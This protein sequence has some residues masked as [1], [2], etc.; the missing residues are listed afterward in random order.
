MLI[1]SKYWN[2]LKEF[3]QSETIYFQKKESI[4]YEHFR[5]IQFYNIYY[6]LTLFYKYIN[7]V[8]IEISFFELC[9]KGIKMLNPN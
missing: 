9:R 5:D 3:T 6:N 1:F 4:G 2:I 7:C 8:H